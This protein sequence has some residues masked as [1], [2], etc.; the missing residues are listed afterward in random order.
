M[1]GLTIT[2]ILTGGAPPTGRG[3][4]I[5]APRCSDRRQLRLPGCRSRR[6]RSRP[7]VSSLESFARAPAWT[8]PPKRRARAGAE[9]ALRASGGCWP[10]LSPVPELLKASGHLG[11]PL[12]L[13][14]CG[15]EDLLP[16]PV[17][18]HPGDEGC[19]V[20]VAA[21]RVKEGVGIARWDDH[22]APVVEDVI[23]RQQ[24]GLLP[25]VA[26]DGRGERGRGLVGQLADHP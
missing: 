2:G 14:A 13:V 26:V 17:P 24:G 25:A 23:E 12:S 3:G 21:R 5:A 20:G 22:R 11:E 10:P 15:G 6:D 19:S 18:L 1:P 7:G 4:Q 8:V 16:W 9:R